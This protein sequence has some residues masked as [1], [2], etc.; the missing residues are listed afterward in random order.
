MRATQC[1][2]TGSAGIWRRE[3]SIKRRSYVPV[4]G[5]YLAGFLPVEVSSAKTGIQL[6]LAARAG[7]LWKQREGQW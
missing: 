1:A 3:G 7:L 5:S 4:P 2:A 6:D